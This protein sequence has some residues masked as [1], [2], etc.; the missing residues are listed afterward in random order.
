MEVLPYQ[1]SF[2]EKLRKLDDGMVNEILHLQD[3][4]PDSAWVVKEKRTI[5][6]FGYLTKNPNDRFVTL[7]FAINLKHA[8]CIEGAA[9]LIETLQGYFLNFKK[10][11]KEKLVLRLWVRESNTLYQQFLE[12]LSFQKKNE[13]WM[14]ERPL[15]K[16]DGNFQD[17][18]VQY[19]DLTKEDA[20]AHYLASN[21]EGF[22]VADS[23]Y[24][25]LY[26]MAHI[27]AEVY[28][29]VSDTG[30]YISCVTTWPEGEK[31]A[32]E[33]VFCK[34]A[35]RKQGYTTRVLKQVYAILWKRGVKAA[36]LNCY[37]KNKEAL[38]LYTHLGYQKKQKLLEYHF[39]TS[40]S[41]V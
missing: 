17:D 1:S 15:Q 14:M 9:L 35:Y 8:L 10:K 3:V 20:M 31:A 2:E 32:T 38:K 11:M 33:D 29:I 28:G 12:E 4:L 37:C 41:P 7:C 27:Q 26:R 25:M 6:S 21:K 16:E 36:T 24:A 5:L 19:L 13:M 18:F 22:L 30:E 23:P 34:T 40:S 39:K